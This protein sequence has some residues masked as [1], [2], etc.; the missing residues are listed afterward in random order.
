MARKGETVMTPKKLHFARCVASGMTQADAYREAYDVKR[1]TNESIHSLASRL[2]ADVKVRARVNTLVKVREAALTRSSLSDRER[3]LEKLRHMMDHATKEDTAKLK[4]AELLGRSQGLF[5]DVVESGDTSTASAA[6]LQ[7]ELEERLNT[8]LGASQQ[9]T[10]AD[11]GDTQVTEGEA[12]T[13]E[14]IAADDSA[15]TL[16]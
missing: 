10:D 4:A 3:V 16:H 13:S 8:L 11:G 5:K 12:D 7:A 14:A 6:E 9:A 2:M 1:A 15:D